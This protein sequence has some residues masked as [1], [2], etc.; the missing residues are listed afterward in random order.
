[1]TPDQKAKTARILGYISVVVGILNFTIIGV[2]AFQGEAERGSPLLITGVAALS[3]GIF[4]V[5]LGRRKPTS[6]D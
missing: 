6:Q 5:A 1:M 4:M 2:Q 3:M